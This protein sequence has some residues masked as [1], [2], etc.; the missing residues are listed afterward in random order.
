M[1]SA[2]AQEVPTCGLEKMPVDADQ[3]HVENDDPSFFSARETLVHVHEVHKVH[4]TDDLIAEIIATAQPATDKNAEIIASAL[5]K[6]ADDPGAVYTPEVIAALKALKD[7]NLADFIRMRAKIKAINKDAM[8]GA[9]D[10]EVNGGDV[11]KDDQ[12]LSDQLVSFVQ[13]R[14]DLFRDQDKNGYAGF[15]AIDHREAWRIDSQGFREWLGAEFYHETNLIPKETPLKDACVALNG[16]AKYDGEEKEVSIRVAKTATGYAVDLVNDAWQSVI[17]SAGT[18]HVDGSQSVIFRR[19]PTMRAMPVPSAH[20][21]GNI[22]LLWQCINCAA[23]DRNMLLA[24]ML[25]CWRSDTAFP[26]LEIVAEQGCGKSKGQHFIRELI[27]PNQVNL[28]GRPKTI[29][30]IYISA[31]N[32]WMASFENLS[33]LT[34]DMQD[35]FCVLATGGGFAGRTLYTN[36]EET[37]VSVKRPIVMNGISVLATRQDLG[38]VRKLL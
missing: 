4:Q 38:S 17:I 1:R 12:S 13:G 34:D 32:S 8:M 28:R 5:E 18:W 25:E 35:A 22:E 29:E 23:S 36:T 30:D 19:T 14:A 26:V 27:D 11:A 6:L 31:T 16:I 15:T 21:T 37:A 9:L 24:W 33:H 20:G 3:M 7:S 2:N 10:K